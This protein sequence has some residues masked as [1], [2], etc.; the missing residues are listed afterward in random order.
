[1]LQQMR[2]NLLLLPLNLGRPETHLEPADSLRSKDALKLPGVF[3]AVTGG[4]ACR[5]VLSP[6]DIKRNEVNFQRHTV[7][8]IPSQRPDFS[9]FNPTLFPLQ[10]PPAMNIITT[11]PFDLFVCVFRSMI[12]HFELIFVAM[13]RYDQFLLLVWGV[14]CTEVFKFSNT[15]CYS[16]PQDMWDLIPDQD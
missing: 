16:A 12:Q 3:S 1:M 14:F 10:P 9:I 6:T 11:D 4:W 2:R 13:A 15:I 5:S 7:Y 8:Q